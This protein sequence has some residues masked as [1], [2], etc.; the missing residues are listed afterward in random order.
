MCYVA[1]CHLEDD[2]KSVMELNISENCEVKMCIKP[3]YA[4]FM[5]F[6]SIVSF[7]K[8]PRNLLG[9]Q[10]QYLV[11]MKFIKRLLLQISQLLHRYVALSY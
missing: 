6:Q 4:V 3:P 8:D 5:V 2:M 11:L 10:A 9:W 1:G 7:S